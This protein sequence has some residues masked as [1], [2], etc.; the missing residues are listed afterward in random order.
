MTAGEPTGDSTRDSWAALDRE[1]ALW[2]AAGRTA[3]LWW[4]D[5]DAADAGPALD[6]LLDIAAQHGVPLAL[7][8]IPDAATPALA[9]RLARAGAGVA[10]LQHGFAHRNHAQAPAKKA[11]LGAGRPAAAALAELH[12]G[13]I[14][15]AALCADIGDR[16][17]P[18][19]V[20]PWNRIA[21]EVVAGL[22]GAGFAGLSSFGART[23]ARPA[24]G[25]LQVNAHVDIVDWHGGRGF[26]GEAVALGRMVDHLAARRLGRVDETEPTG[27]MSHHLAHDAACWR[28][29]DRL[30]A[31]V[32]GQRA[33]IWLD[34]PSI[35]NMPPDGD[36][37]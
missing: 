2:A 10:V 17:L 8:V 20:P 5:D 13:R 9:G 32:A 33:A 26:V 27:L 35:F 11:E 6:R 22:A 3:T 23:G 16:P 29:C 7:A 21:P 12:T 37:P 4:R 14:R 18:V 25:L 30:A 19:V 24:P 28:F 15:L 1:L 31:R 36:L 34:A